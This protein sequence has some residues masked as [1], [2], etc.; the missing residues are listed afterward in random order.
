MSVS[1]INRVI[2]DL[3]GKKMTK[4]QLALQDKLRKKVKLKEITVKEAHKI[5]NKEFPKK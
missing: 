5:W 2:R 4:K 3:L 1:E